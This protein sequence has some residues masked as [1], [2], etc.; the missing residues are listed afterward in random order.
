M[1]TESRF[2]GRDL[3]P[4]D[5]GSERAEAEQMRRRFLSSTL[6]YIMRRDFPRVVRG[7]DPSEV[8]AHLETVKGWFAMG[9]LERMAQELEDE[10]LARIE[11]RRAEARA[12]ADTIV[13]DA[14]GEADRILAEAREQAEQ[15]LAEARHEADRA[16]ADGRREYT[17]L[18][19]R[20]QV[21]S[22]RLAE[23][24]RVAHERSV[25]E[26]RAEQAQ[27][28]SE[29]EIVRAARVEAAGIVDTATSESARVRT[30]CDAYVD[31][32]LGE[33]EDVLGK[34]LR[35]VNRGRSQLWRTSPATAAS[36]TGMDLID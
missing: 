4:T 32:K 7:Y 25:A 24:G 33:F 27:L 14:K 9:G 2:N 8:E 23:A 36:G 30:E 18:V 31:R 29:T 16:V 28:V 35:T 6:G 21:E 34:A 20:A 10:T 17:E 13:E 3:T 11:E 1:S 22:E 15:L 12:E 19:D 26:G 5:E